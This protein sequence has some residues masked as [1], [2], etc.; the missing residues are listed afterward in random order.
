MVGTSVLLVSAELI[1][2]VERFCVVI[3]ESIELVLD[4]I[5]VVEGFSELES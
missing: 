3:E 5:T 1:D 2:S 4:S